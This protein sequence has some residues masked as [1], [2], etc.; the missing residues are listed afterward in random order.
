[1][2]KLYNI[3]GRVKG[4]GTP[5]DGERQP[6]KGRLKCHNVMRSPAVAYQIVTLLNIHKYYVV[7]RQIG[8]ALAAWRRG[9]MR[10]P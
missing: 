1:M 10:P 5:K 6:E 7:R 2:A 8:A 4:E 9:R 3:V